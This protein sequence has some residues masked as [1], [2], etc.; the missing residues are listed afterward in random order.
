[1]ANSLNDLGT[2]VLGKLPDKHV[3]ASPRT[4]S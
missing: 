4:A 2:H 3:A 1:M